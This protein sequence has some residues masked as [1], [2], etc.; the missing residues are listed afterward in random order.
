M[1]G[2]KTIG[3]DSAAFAMAA[4]PVSSSP[5]VPI[6]AGV[7]RRAAVGVDP[8]RVSLLLAVLNRR[9][10]IHVADQDVFVNVVGGV[11][12]IEPASDLAV[13]AAVASSALGRPIDP[14]AVC[15]GELGLAGEVRAV[16]RPEP[17]LREAERMGFHRAIVARGN[18]G[19]LAAGPEGIEVCGVV[20]LERALE[21]MLQ[22]TRRS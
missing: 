4:R 15:F 5:V 21:A 20:D 6:T 18:A 11:R 13:A 7:P 1:F 22:V 12:L 3:T 10:G 8:N 19:A 16:A 2:A 14:L 9:A 17:R